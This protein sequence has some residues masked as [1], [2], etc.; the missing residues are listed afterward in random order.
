MPL[1]PRKIYTLKLRRKG[2]EKELSQSKWPQ[3]ASLSNK[4]QLF[5]EFQFICQPQEDTAS[6]HNT[7][8]LL[9]H[10]IQVTLMP[11]RQRGPLHF[12]L[13]DGIGRNFQ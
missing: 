10:Q 1:F 2:T 6:V 5:Y 13:K 12:D 11:L 4:V 7:F 8:F 9:I 3:K